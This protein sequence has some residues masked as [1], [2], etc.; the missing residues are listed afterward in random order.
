MGPQRL[1]KYR[2]A[3]V[4]PKKP[5]PR[6]QHVVTARLVPASIVGRRRTRII[7]ALL[8]GITPTVIARD[9]YVAR[10]AVYKVASEEGRL[11]PR[12]RYS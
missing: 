9:Q 3:K 5:R 10:G 8:H 11:P 7:A 1:A 2:A 12:R 6:M 4:A